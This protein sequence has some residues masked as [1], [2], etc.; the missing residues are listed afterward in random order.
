M[1]RIR[2]LRPASVQQE[3]LSI[4]DENWQDLVD[5]VRAIDLPE[6]PPGEKRAIGYQRVGIERI[7]DLDFDSASSQQLAARS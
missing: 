3:W 1:V 5:L 6:A 4:A 2:V 7:S